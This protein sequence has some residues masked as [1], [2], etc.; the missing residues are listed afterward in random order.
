[1]QHIGLTAVLY[2][3]R[4]LFY[5]IMLYHIHFVF[6]YLHFFQIS[7]HVCCFTR[8]LLSPVV[9]SWYAMKLKLKHFDKDVL[10]VF[11]FK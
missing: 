10:I 5:I 7:V 9:C 4:K 6:R 3:L 1:M 2:D 8:V 11:T